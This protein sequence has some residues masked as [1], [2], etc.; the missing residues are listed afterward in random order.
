MNRNPNPVDPQNQS[1]KQFLEIYE[2]MLKESW[3]LAIKMVDSI[4]RE[5]AK[6]AAKLP[7]R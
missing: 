3:S 2:K 4:E 5:R 6:A 7:V 1:S